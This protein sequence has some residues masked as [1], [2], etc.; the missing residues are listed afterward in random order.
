MPK[1]NLCNISSLLLFSSFIAISKSESFVHP[2]FI[3]EPNN[4]IKEISYFK[5]QLYLDVLKFFTKKLSP[6]FQGFFV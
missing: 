1:N 2:P 4:L 3:L 6:E 5:S